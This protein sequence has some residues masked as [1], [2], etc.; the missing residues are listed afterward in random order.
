M[1]VGIQSRTQKKIEEHGVAI[2][3]GTKSETDPEFEMKGRDHAHLGPDLEMMVAWVLA[4][5]SFRP[6]PSN[7]A[8]QKPLHPKVPVHII[9]LPPAMQIPVMMLFARMLVGYV[10]DCVVMPM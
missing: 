5:H 9:V 4:T 7:A 10:S 2:E 8:S 6:S 3:L 1:Q